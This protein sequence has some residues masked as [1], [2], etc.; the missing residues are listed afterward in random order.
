M[1]T[2][3][4]CLHQISTESL[5]RII[6][7]A[8]PSSDHPEGALQPQRP[9]LQATRSTAFRAKPALEEYTLEDEDG[10][11]VGS[12][13]HNAEEKDTDVF[14]EAHDS[15]EEV[16]CSFELPCRLGSS[17][18]ITATGHTAEDFRILIRRRTTH[19]IDVQ[20]KFEGY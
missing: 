3:L 2:A 7:I 14:F 10:S 9:A 17:S 8:V 20:V 19:D 18:S 12:H 4:I 1:E 11:V 16:S 5:M 13:A 6:D 15:T